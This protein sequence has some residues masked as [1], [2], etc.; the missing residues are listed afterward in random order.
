MYVKYYCPPNSTYYEIIN[1]SW[2]H[3]NT[4]SFI[5]PNTLTNM[6]SYLPKTIKEWNSLLEGTVIADL[7]I[8]FCDKLKL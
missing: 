4:I 8:D 1:T 6:Y 3:G 7:F 5:Y 2:R